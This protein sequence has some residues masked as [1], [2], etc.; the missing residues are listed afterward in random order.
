MLAWLNAINSTNLRILVTLGVVIATAARYLVWGVPARMSGNIP[1]IDGWGYWL[2]FLGGMAGLDVAQYVGKRFSDSGYAA[3]KNTPA[4]PVTVTTPAP[5][6]IDASAAPV[7]VIDR[8]VVTVGTL[9]AGSV[10]DVDTSRPVL[11]DA[12]TRRAADNEAS[13]S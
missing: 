12:H 8:N 13:D 5:V 2:V 11:G 4:A 1:V 7:R 6:S 3:A 10:L 9:A